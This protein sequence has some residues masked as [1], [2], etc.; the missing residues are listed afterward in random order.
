[1]VSDDAITYAKMQDTSAA[2]K[3]LGAVSAGTV[4]EVSIATDMIADAQ[5]DE[6]KL[7][8]SNNPTNGYFYQHN[9]VIQVE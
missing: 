1:M 5:V 8:I 3:V 9:L 2:N 6:A 4:G 7:K